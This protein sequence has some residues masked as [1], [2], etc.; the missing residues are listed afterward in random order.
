MTSIFRDT[1]M[2][3]LQDQMGGETTPQVTSGNS[4][5]NENAQ[6]AELEDFFSEASDRW[7]S[8]AFAEKK[9]MP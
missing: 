7:A 6:G 8:L 5:V 1:A 4:L 9:T 2:T 3:T